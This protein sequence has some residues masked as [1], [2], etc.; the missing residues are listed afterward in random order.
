VLKNAATTS[1]PVAHLDVE[2]VQ[3]VIVFVDQCSREKHGIYATLHGCATRAGLS[4]TVVAVWQDEFG[5]TRF[6]APP[7][8]HPF[9]RITG[10]DQL[11]AQVNSKIEC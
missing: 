5:R 2:D 1:F 9:F 11:Y 3:L 6:I 8:Q 7:E 4:G 10:Y